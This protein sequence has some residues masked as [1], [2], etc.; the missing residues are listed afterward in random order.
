MDEEVKCKS[1]GTTKDVIFG[2]DLY[3]SELYGDDTE[4]WM[5]GNCRH[6]SEM[7]I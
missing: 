1:C 7:D 2:R 6:E 5:C 4:V 3:M